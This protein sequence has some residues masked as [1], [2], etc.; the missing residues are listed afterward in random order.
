MKASLLIFCCLSL[1]YC[2]KKD[3]D[4]NSLSL[5]NPLTTSKSD[6]ITVDSAKIPSA[7]VEVE[8]QTIFWNTFSKLPTRFSNESDANAYLFTDQSEIESNGVKY[9]VCDFINN[10]VVL[11]V[12]GAFEKL[13]DISGKDSYFENKIYEN[14]NFRLELNL[15]EKVSEKLKNK[16]LK[17]IPLEG[18]YVLK[19]TLKLIDLKNNELLTLVSDKNNF[20]VGFPY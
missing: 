6:T 5:T 7:I 19:G 12:N 8:K 14:A 20:K 13:N 9:G 18:A 3:T 11:K 10:V 2:K 15:D 17:D 1:L 4:E 16:I